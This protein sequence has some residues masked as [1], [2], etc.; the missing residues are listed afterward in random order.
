MIQILSKFIPHICPRIIDRTEKDNYKN[1]C[2]RNPYRL[3]Q[4]RQLRSVC[5][6][7]LIQ[8]RKLLGKYCFLILSC[9]HLNLRPQQITHR[10]LQ[11]IRQPYQQLRI[12]YRQ[13][14]FPFRNSL[15]HHVQPE[16]QLFLRKPLLF[17]KYLQI[18]MKHIASPFP[19]LM[20]S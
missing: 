14:L 9:R 16:R 15:P 10:H 20:P 17:S 19:S 1:Q 3:L 5:N 2:Q 7:N 12:R 11:H 8:L 4:L 18:F 13:P 6:Q